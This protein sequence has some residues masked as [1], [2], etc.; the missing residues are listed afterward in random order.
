MNSI[1]QY[2]LSGLSSSVFVGKHASRWQSHGQ[3]FKQ[4]APFTANDDAR[5][6]D[7]RA[8]V[9]DP[10][11][12]YQV[13]HYQQH[14]LLTVYLIA[15]LSAS[16]SFAGQQAKRDSLQQLLQCIADSALAVGDYFAFIGCGQ[17]IESS[18]L[19]PAN[20][21][22]GYIEQFAKTLKNLTYSANCQS[23]ADV[24]PYLPQQR[25]L[26]FLLSDFHFP[27]ANLPQL[28]HAIKH[29]DVVPLVLWDK[30]EYE[31]LPAWGLVSYRDMENGNTRTL[32]MRP[33]LKHSIRAA[34][35]TRQQQLQ[36]SLRALGHEPLFLTTQP[37]A[38]QLNHY[39]RQR[40][41]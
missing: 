40:S 10:F 27:L 9:L 15:D 26:I 39:F 37:V 5:R 20:R 29:H 21:H 4:H 14:S 33:A 1:F 18:W 17:R 28:L 30:Q 38:E 2:R 23:L 36:H 32:W 19:L 41:R 13:R 22:S 7:I 31:Q 24:A 34:Y 11:E 3:L 25:A 35:Q 8:S 12:R 16:L 6:I